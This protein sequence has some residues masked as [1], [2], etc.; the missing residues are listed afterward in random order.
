MKPHPRLRAR[1][2]PEYG[3][4]KGEALRAL[5][6]APDPGQRAWLETELEKLGVVL[7]I[8]RNVAELVSALVEDPPPRPQL[9]FVELTTMSAGELLHLHTIR[10]LGWFGAVI[11]IGKAPLAL[12]QSLMIER[13]L[14]PHA[15]H[16]SV[17]GAIANIAPGA[18]TL[19]VPR[20]NG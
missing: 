4:K 14:S 7:Q 13:V 6:Y 2:T 18:Q 12:R 1:G 17:R 3:R 8:A 5:I 16:D 10:E 15:S 11:A 20:I 19:R 9:L